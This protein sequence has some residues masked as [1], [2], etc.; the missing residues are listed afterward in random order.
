VA[1]GFGI[2]AAR[3]STGNL[4]FR[5]PRRAYLAY[6]DKEL[7]FPGELE[8]ARETD[9]T[10]LTFEPPRTVGVPGSLLRVRTW[11]ARFAVGIRIR[12]ETTMMR[13]SQ[14][15]RRRTVPCVKP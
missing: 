8:S 1:Y 5:F 14:C 2:F 10:S 7:A 12:N 6:G 3:L 4:N 15:A 11:G 13:M 9:T